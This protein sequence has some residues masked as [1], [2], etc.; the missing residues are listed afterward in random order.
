M[1]CFLSFWKSRTVGTLS[2][3]EG[4]SHQGF[5]ASYRPPPCESHQNGLSFGFKELCGGREV[6]GIQL[7]SCYKL[8]KGS[9][10]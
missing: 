7:L 3:R 1:T 2:L 9:L 5:S 4:R 8:P 10:I 6:S